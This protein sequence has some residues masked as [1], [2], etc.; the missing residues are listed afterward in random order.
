[1]WKMQVQ[2]LCWEDPLKKG[3]GNPL[4]YSCLENPNPG[5]TEDSDMTGQPNNNKV[6]LQRKHPGKILPA[7]AEGVR[8][9]SREKSYPTE[10]CSHCQTV[11]GQAGSRW[12]NTIAP[13]LLSN[14]AGPSIGWT[15]PDQQGKAVSVIEVVL[16]SRSGEWT[17]DLKE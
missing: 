2:S 13:L 1:M 8:E 3:N 5:V 6:N 15:Q 10:K 16:Q 17:V 14:P 7:Q 12:I 9:G 11:T 4:Q